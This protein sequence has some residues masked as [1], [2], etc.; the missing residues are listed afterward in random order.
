MPQL[1]LK[2]ITS[3]PS[4]VIAGLTLLAILAFA[5]VTR[6]V[7]RFGEQQKALARHL[8]EQAMK[9]RQ[10]GKPDSA[11]EHFRD[12][13]G[14]SPDNFEY[15]LQLSRALRDTGRTEEAEAY[16]VSLWERSPQDGAVNL[17]LGRLAVRQ[18]SLDKAMQYY[19]SAIYG[20]W[21]SDADRH[22]TEAWFELI[23]FLIQQNARP[24]A[25]AELITLAAELPPQVDF[26]LRLAELFVRTSDYQ[27]ALNEY[28]EVVKL[29]RSNQVALV[30]SGEMAFKLGR[31][32]VA[33]HYLQAAV[34][35]DPHDT[36][37]ARLLEICQLVQARDPFRPE[38]SIEERNRRLSTIFSEA[39]R[40][41]DSCMASQ[42]ETPNSAQPQ[43]ALPSLK[44]DWDQMRRN[45]GLLRSSSEAG[46]PGEVMYLVLRIEQQT[47]VCTP[48]PTDEA[49]MLLAQNRAGTIP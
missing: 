19:H 47:Q 31:Y 36:D 14:Y 27:R 32:A 34:E 28:A 30:G 41:L 15:Q 12:A 43:A 16:L 35:Q 7:N 44:A 18:G 48:T 45:L 24:Q 40:R 6:L 4:A 9:E 25:Q 46:L 1:S 2:P 42:S 22:R 20:M 23:E 8:Y 38:I 49:L 29:D 5:G 13:L 39:G 11:I 3:R 17:A 10:S 33:E 26:H 21:P 37:S